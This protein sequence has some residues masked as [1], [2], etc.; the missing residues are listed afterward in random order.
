MV[1]LKRLTQAALQDDP[2]PQPS[3]SSCI[4]NDAPIVN[5]PQISAR[6]DNRPLG[7]FTC[8]IC[9]RP[10]GNMAN[11]IAHRDVH[12]NVP[13]GIPT[14]MSNDFASIHISECALDRHFCIYDMTSNEP[15]SDVLQFYQM[16]VGL[17]KKLIVSLSSTH[18]LQGEW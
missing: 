5:S 7:N 13:T 11:L 1:C 10:H 4:R 17:V 18:V 9:G 8:N 2:S 15:C 14:S 12:S 6:N 3:I 16:S